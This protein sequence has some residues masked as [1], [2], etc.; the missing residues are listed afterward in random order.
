MNIGKYRATLVALAMIV[1]ATTLIRFDGFSDKT[2]TVVVPTTSFI[3]TA[4][5]GQDVRKIVA[6]TGARVNRDLAVI[7]S[8]EVRLTREQTEQLRANKAVTLFPN[9]VVRTTSAVAQA[10]SGRRA[11]P[12]SHF[13]VQIGADVL[14][15]RGI[16]GA[17]TTVAI[18]D[19]GLWSRHPAIAR[20]TAGNK[21]VVAEYNSKRALT[22]RDVDDGTGHGTH[23]ASVI[24]SSA[25]SAS[26][27]AHGVAPDARL[28]NIKAFDDEG[29]GSYGSVIQG[30]AWAIAHREEHNIRVLNLSISTEAR[31]PYW[32]DP[33]NRIVMMAWHSGIVVI[34]SAGNTGP[35]AMTVGVPGNVPYIITVGAPRPTTSLQHYP[36]DDRLAYFTSFRSDGRWLR[37][38][39]LCRSGR[40]PLL[41]VMNARKHLLAQQHPEFA[42]DHAESLRD[43]RYV[44]SGRSRQWCC[45]AHA[46]CGTVADAEPGQMP[47]NG[48]RTSRDQ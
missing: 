12:E 11:G 20:D 9:A 27:V 17:N 39:G 10:R 40:S 33:L 36:V 22:G 15:E 1:L 31:S 2:Q 46:G 24:A 3:V 43:V 18:L 30:I 25:Y 13:P 38:A 21:R 47:T 6:A 5:S 23:L 14:H 16:T 34:T 4:R 35:D 8:V 7:N 26:G 41:G 45:R 44:A 37:E 32:A 42:T 19:S 29:Y 48:Y 28:V